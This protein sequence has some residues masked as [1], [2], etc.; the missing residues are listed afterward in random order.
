MRPLA[1]ITSQIVGK[2]YQLGK[3]DCFSIIIIYLKMIGC[4]I[5]KSFKGETL[6]T[7][8]DLYIN[9]PEKAKAL[10]IEFMQSLLEE[11]P[12]H[13]T[14]A[15]DILLLQLNNDLPFFGINGGNGK[16]ISACEI[17]GVQVLPL[18]YYKILKVFKC[19]QQF[20]QH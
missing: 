9:E 1:E 15:G 19:R 7:Y 10:M 18:Q 2:T 20:Q 12:V 4:K 8:K 5:P 16:F 11:I 3:V 6:S 14:F 17:Q 13:K